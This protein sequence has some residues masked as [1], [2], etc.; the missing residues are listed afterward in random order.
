MNPFFGFIIIFLMKKKLV[1][2]YQIVLFCFFFF[3][4]GYYNDISAASLQFDP[5]SANLPLN[6]NLEVKVI[7]DAGT[8][9]IT[10]TDAY[11]HYDS[12][13]LEVVEVKNGSFFPTVTH[14]YSQT[15]K[16]YIAGMVEDPT[17]FK[18]GRGILATI[19]FKGKSNGQANLSFDCND[20]STTDS[21]ITKKDINASDIIQCQLNN[22]AT[23]NV[24]L[25]SYSQSQTQGGSSNQSQNQNSYNQQLP[26]SGVFDQFKSFSLVG[27][28]FLVIGTATRFL[29]R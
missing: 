20:G 12:N 11:I 2:F 15:G 29:L 26:Q 27:F 6:Q 16:V 1:F 17:T 25:T 21:N 18:T 28:V 23:I 22:R 4:L 13:L 14:D 7:V 9:E 19:V 10:S 8:D 3:T 24:G 5:T